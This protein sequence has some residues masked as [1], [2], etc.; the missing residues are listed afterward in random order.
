MG[1]L[2]PLHYALPAQ[3]PARSGTIV[4][5]VK[6]QGGA[7]IQDAQVQILPLPN[8]IGKNLKTGSDGNL[9]LTVPPGSYE[10]RVTSPGFFT[11]AKRIEVQNNTPQR[12]DVVLKVG[13]CPPGPCLVVSSAVPV[14]SADQARA[15]SSVSDEVAQPA[16]PEPKISI[17]IKT[18]QNTVAVGSDVQVEV[19]MKN[20][21]QEG[22]GFVPS[23]T[24]S[25]STTSFRWDIRDSAGKPVPMTDY[26]LK[27]NCLDSPG[28]APRICAGSSFADI[29][30]PGRSLNE[31]LALSKEYDLSRP[32]RYTIQALKFDGE[33]AVKSNII[34]L[35]VTP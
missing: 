22:V 9:P 7:I 6:D 30:N 15:A 24:M 2:T 32:G 13:S 28:G 20:I 25:Y 1:M 8:T 3:E 14:S 12:I 19:A 21:S 31:K 16:L 35:T 33:L 4:I 17:T 5:E 18:A 27:A 29:L 34:I 23:G 11:Y 10:L 26:G